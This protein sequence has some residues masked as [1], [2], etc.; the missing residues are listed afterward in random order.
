MVPITH[1]T[2]NWQQPDWPN[3][4]YEVQRLE[5]KESLFLNRGGILVG[6]FKHLN[7]IV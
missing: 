2:W 1:K 4:R 3:F 6:T 5:Q 7:P